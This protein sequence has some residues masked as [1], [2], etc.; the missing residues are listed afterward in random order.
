MIE[1]QLAVF[2]PP[3]APQTTLFA[4]L[5]ASGSSGAS[6]A[7]S[8][9]EDDGVSGAA[10]HVQDLATVGDGDQHGQ[11]LDH[12]GVGGGVVASRVVAGQGVLL[13]VIG[14][15]KHIFRRRWIA[16]CSLCGNL[17]SLR[18]AIKY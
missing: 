15:Q 3:E 11:A 7:A 6:G 17:W 8:G 2:V 10:G 5:I 13:D 16:I 18:V 4:A 9:A 1:P 14:G 12:N